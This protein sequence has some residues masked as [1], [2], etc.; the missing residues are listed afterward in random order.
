VRHVR[1]SHNIDKLADSILGFM[2]K[3][4]L[5]WLEALSLLNMLGDGVEAIGNVEIVFVGNFYKPFAFL[6]DRLI[7]YC[8]VK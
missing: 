2:Q 8:I 6:Y 1:H 7:A 4:F 3:H 5:H